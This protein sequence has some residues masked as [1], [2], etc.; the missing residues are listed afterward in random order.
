MTDDV[1]GV[2]EGE[3]ASFRP[4]MLWL[5]AWMLSYMGTTLL[6]K[7]HVLLPGGVSWLVAVLP[8]GV[9][10]AACAFYLRFLARCGSTDR[11]R[12]LFAMSL[13][14]LGGAFTIL[15]YR[16]L[17]RAGAPALDFNDPFVAMAALWGVGLLV[18]G[19]R[20]SS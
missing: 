1:D 6:F 4:V 5:L 15:G 12:H 3:E 18:S 7:V 2:H 14:L 17:E 13:G 20:A 8:S 19:R 9:G 16:L 11:R 10:A